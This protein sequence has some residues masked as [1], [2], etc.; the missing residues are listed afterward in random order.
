MNRPKEFWIFTRPDG[1]VTCSSRVHPDDDPDWTDAPKDG[2][3]GTWSDVDALDWATRSDACISGRCVHGRM[4]TTVSPLPADW[5]ESL[6]RV[7][8]SF[9]ELIKAW[10]DVSP[11]I[12]PVFDMLRETLHVYRFEGS[13]HGVQCASATGASLCFC[14]CKACVATDGE[15]GCAHCGC[16]S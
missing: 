8:R 4:D 5:T 14:A 10:N 7:T 9:E 15:C 12:L 16:E 3:R 6:A 11:R 13:G 2:E 1:H